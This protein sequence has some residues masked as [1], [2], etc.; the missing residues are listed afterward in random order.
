M[1][2]DSTPSIFDLLKAEE[3]KLDAFLDQMV[4]IIESTLPKIEE[5]NNKSN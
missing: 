5:K 1:Q 4:S 2:N 3:Q